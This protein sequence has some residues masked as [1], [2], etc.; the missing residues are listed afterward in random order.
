MSI[1]RESIYINK[2]FFKYFYVLRL[3]TPE[4]IKSAVIDAWLRA[5]TRDNIALELEVAEGTVSN[6]I[7][8]WKNRIS[9][10][11]ANNLRELGL[12]L[13]KAGMSP[14]QCVNRLRVN[15]IINQLGIDEDHLKDFLGKLYYESKEQRLPPADIARLVRDK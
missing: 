4:H 9:V 1:F 15:N 10:F 2:S 6:V 14:I 8:Q 13:K 5:E 11:D 7:E 12:A 3:P